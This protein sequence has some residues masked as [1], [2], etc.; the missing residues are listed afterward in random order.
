MQIK[1]TLAIY[2]NLKSHTVNAQSCVLQLS[3]SLPDVESAS[4]KDKES[5]ALDTSVATDSTTEGSK[6]SQ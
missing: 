5:T 6:V 3:F 1:S 4:T 2:D